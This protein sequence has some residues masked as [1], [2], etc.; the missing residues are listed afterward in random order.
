M[1]SDSQNKSELIDTFSDRDFT[2][3]LN[4]PEKKY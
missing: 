3:S 1:L 4:L 2:S